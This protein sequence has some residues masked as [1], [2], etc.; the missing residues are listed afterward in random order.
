MNRLSILFSV[1]FVILCLLASSTSFA[2][3]VMVSKGKF[4]DSSSGQSSMEQISKMYVSDEEIRTDSMSS[5]QNETANSMIYRYLSGKDKLLIIDHNKRGYREITN[6][7]VQGLKAQVEESMKKMEEAMKQV[8]PEM[9]KMFKDKMAQKMPKDLP[10]V[11]LKKVGSGLE[12]RDW[13]CDKYE[14]YRGGKKVSE[15]WVTKV[16]GV[17]EKEYKVF[18]HMAAFLEDFNEIASG[19]GGGA[20]QE[21]GYKEKFFRQ[22]LYPVK[23]VNYSHGKRVNEWEL[24]KMEKK[25]IP[26]SIFEVPEGYRKQKSQ[27]NNRR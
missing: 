25:D 4:Y 13:V 6:E 9:R 2:G 14:A 17:N 11:E 1:S 7:D 26:G 5:G 18:S 16:S 22:G 10:P 12:F 23:S 27:F 8:P 19:F 20:R 3:L 15:V 24:E 21:F